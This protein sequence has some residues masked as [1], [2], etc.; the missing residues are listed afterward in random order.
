MLKPMCDSFTADMDSLKNTWTSLTTVLIKKVDTVAETLDDFEKKCW[1]PVKKAIDVWNFDETPWMWNKKEDEVHT[2]LQKV[3][4]CITKFPSQKRFL[5]S[6]SQEMYDSPEK[7]T[8]ETAIAL[9]Q[10]LQPRIDESTKNSP[11]SS[12]AVLSLRIKHRRS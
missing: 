8:L 1:E 10:R 6:V 9:L 2:M 7:K 11:T 4:L 12:C 5:E 3:H